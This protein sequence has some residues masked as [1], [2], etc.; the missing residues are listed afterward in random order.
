MVLQLLNPSHIGAVYF[1]K[2]EFSFLMIHVH[3]H[4]MFSNL[5]ANLY[6]DIPMTFD[7]WFLIYKR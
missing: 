7:R 4:L 3:A 2:T 1:Y 5:R 6:S